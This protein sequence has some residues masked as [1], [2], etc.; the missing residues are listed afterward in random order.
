MNTFLKNMLSETQPTSI[1]RMGL[2]YPGRDAPG[3]S[4]SDKAP[5]KGGRDAGSAGAAVA[6]AA[7]H[8]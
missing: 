8:R 3:T 1:T 2:W 7:A 6:M 4:Q 5:H